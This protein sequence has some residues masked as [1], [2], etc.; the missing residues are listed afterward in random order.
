MIATIAITGIVKA[1]KS[2]ADIGK[3]EQSP[4]LIEAMSIQIKPTKGEIKLALASI[5]EKYGLNLDELLSVIE[6]ESGFRTDEYSPGMISYGVAQFTKDTFKENCA[7]DYKNPFAQISCMGLMW[8]KGMQG[9]WDCYR[10]LYK[11]N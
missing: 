1:P 2:T 9:R 6:C 5:S 11:N 10:M 8:S 3:T 7:G 4:D